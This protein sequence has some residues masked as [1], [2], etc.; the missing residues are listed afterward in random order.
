MIGARRNR[1]RAY[2]DI[3]PGFVDGLASLLMVVIFLLM[4]FVLAQY[5]LSE[6]L[7][8]RD[9][10][11]SRLNRELAELSDMLAIERQSNAELRDTVGQLSQELQVITASRDQLSDQLSTMTSQFE[12]A[13]ATVESLKAELEEA[14]RLVQA[15]KERIELQL[16]EIASLRDQIA[17]LTRARDA[18]ESDLAQLREAAERTETAEAESERMR[19]ELEQALAT[20]QEKTAEAETDQAKIEEQLAEIQRLSQSIEALRTARER[21]EAELE[22]ERAALQDVNRRLASEQELSQAS[23]EEVERLTSVVT[24]LRQELAQLS[25]A[26]EVAE[27]ANESKDA[28]ILDLGRR[29]NRALANKVEELARYRSEFFGRLR[30]V[31]GDRQD[32]RIVGD[33]FVFQS[34]VLFDS[35][36]AQF[37]AAGRGQIQEIAETLK[38]VADEIPDDIDWVLR[39]DGHTDVR[40][41]S[42]AQ[43]RSNWELSTARAIAVVRLL[44]DEGIPPERLVAAGFGQFHPIEPGDSLEAYRR[45]RRIE[46]KLTER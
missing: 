29:L 13:T 31:L 14:E 8:G 15:D 2:T 10:Q 34:E 11:L 43:Y 25:A 12:I 6:A 30:E 5:F 39:V 19:S 9:E 44:I 38:Q 21:L 4:V 17:A 40:P 7:S 42:S 36:S 41:I 22:E 46:F 18:L 20:L 1:I 33:R 16:G 37:A 35:G 23:K 26:L 45:N 28:Q 27:S 3:W 24:A 32:I